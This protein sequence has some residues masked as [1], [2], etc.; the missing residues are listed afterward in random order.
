VAGLFGQQ[1][2]FGK[3][4]KEKKKSAILDLCCDVGLF[5]CQQPDA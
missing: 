2:L 1:Y 5:L 3:E 4:K